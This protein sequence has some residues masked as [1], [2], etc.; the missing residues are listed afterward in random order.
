M[1]LISAWNAEMAVFMLLDLAH[2]IYR[3]AF[4]EGSNDYTVGRG[5]HTG[6]SQLCVTDRQSKVVTQEGD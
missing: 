5:S 2:Y 6:T 3:V 4:E 1:A